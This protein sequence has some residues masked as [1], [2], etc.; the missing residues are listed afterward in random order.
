M[1]LLDCQLRG[2]LT[3]FWDFDLQILKAELNRFAKGF[4]FDKQIQYWFVIR[5]SAIEPQP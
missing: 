5:W 2:A 1:G 4:G 3:S